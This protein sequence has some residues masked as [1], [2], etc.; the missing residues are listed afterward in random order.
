ME[1]VTKCR[2]HQQ[3]LAC[4]ETQ[5]KILGGKSYSD[6]ILTLQTSNFTMTQNVL[7]RVHYISANHTHREQNP[8]DTS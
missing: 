8:D 3:L 7:N 6:P 5:T 4:N 2:R 1:K